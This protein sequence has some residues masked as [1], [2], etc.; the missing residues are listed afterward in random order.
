MR[1]LKNGARRVGIVFC[2]ALLCGA[3]PATSEDARMKIGVLDFSTENAD[4]NFRMAM[5]QELVELVRNIG[6]YE[7]FS[8]TAI[9]DIYEQLKIT[10]P[11]WCRDP[12][13]VRDVGST[14]GM[15]RMIFGAID[16]NSKTYG[17][18]LQLID[19]KTKQVIET[20]SLAGEPGVEPKDLLAVAV[21]KLHGRTDEDLG[22]K[23]GEYYGPEIHNEKEW[24]YSSSICMGVGLLWAL[25]NGSFRGEAESPDWQSQWDNGRKSGIPTSVY[26]VP[27]FGR[28]AAL[29]NAYVA[30]ADDAYGVM[31]NPAGASWV[32]SREAT[33][34]YQSRFFLLNNFAAAYV[35]KATREIGFGQVF[36]YSGDEIQN[37]VFFVSAASYRFNRLLPFLRPLSVG[38]SVKL[39]SQTTSAQDPNATSEGSSFGMGFDA[40]VLWELSEQIRYGISFRDLLAFERVN[41]SKQ[42]Y[43]YTEMQPV[44]LQMGGLFKAGYTTQL[45]ANG[46]IPLYPDQ[47]WSMAG[48]IE[49]E[50]FQ[51][52]NIRLGIEREI[53]TEI[54]P[55]WKFTG[56]IGVDAITESIFGKFFAADVSYEFS[57]LALMPVANVSLRFGF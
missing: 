46:R 9:R 55:T 44:T 54:D 51:V 14:T 53:Q 23:V 40:G 6:F 42:G 28:P 52:V 57:T 20:V 13:C 36:Y 39:H 31:Y 24:L 11:K 5:S 19:V 25:A 1:F 32:E 33:V 47:V 27:M 34:G 8:Q 29:A 2:V 35:N 49:Q 15:D 16:K 22:I 3:L 41:N 45:F 48:G 50:I 12:R 56:G 30:A 37:D 26:H 17:V 4:E 21:D 38:G 10:F 7:V 43:S 18:Q